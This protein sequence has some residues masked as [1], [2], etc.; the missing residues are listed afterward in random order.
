MRRW[1]LA[2]ALAALVVVQAVRSWIEPAPPPADP[3]GPRVVVVQP[4]VPQDQRGESDQAMML[5]RVLPLVRDIR[6][7]GSAAYDICSFAAGRLDA[8]Y[9][10][11][12]QPWDYAAALLIA[13]PAPAAA[14]NPHRARW[15]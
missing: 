5:A 11:G 4:N 3:R 7:S 6:R 14:C 15:R 1:P 10:H 2:A 8:F 9:E 12:L 13:R